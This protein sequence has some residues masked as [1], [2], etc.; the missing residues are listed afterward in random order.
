MV[1]K[2]IL[3]DAGQ[4]FQVTGFANQGFSP[5]SFGWQHQ[6]KATRPVPA[7]FSDGRV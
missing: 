4:Y 1:G 7:L 2:V 3:G 5:G 6:Q